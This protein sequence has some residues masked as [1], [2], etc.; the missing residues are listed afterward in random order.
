MQLVAVVPDDLC[1]DVDH[2]EREGSRTEISEARSE[3]EA[4]FGLLQDIDVVGSEEGSAVAFAAVM[5]AHMCMSM[6]FQ[7][8]VSRASGEL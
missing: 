2:L 5:N 1:A 8:A 4:Y 6:N 7:S 3:V